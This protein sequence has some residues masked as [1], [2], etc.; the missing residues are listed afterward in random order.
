MPAMVQCVR[1]VARR[2][3]AADTEADNENC[4]RI[5]VGLPKAR[6]AAYRAS[7]DD[8]P[9]SRCSSSSNVRSDCSSR[10]RSAFLFVIR[11]HSILVLLSGGPHH[12]RHGF[13]HL[14]P[15]RLFDDELFSAFLGEPVVLELPVAV[16]GHLPLGS[17]P[18]SLLEPM[19]CRIQRSVLHLE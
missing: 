18:P 7:P 11:H 13:S 6:R 2:R 9:R 1:L 14:L 8:S 15:L 12:A 10:F 3:S 16:G 17:D 5:S 4:S 19:Q